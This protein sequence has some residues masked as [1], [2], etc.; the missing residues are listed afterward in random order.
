MWLFFP[1]WCE[2]SIAKWKFYEVSV[3]TTKTESYKEK[4]QRALWCQPTAAVQTISCKPFQNSSFLLT[5]EISPPGGSSEYQEISKTLRKSKYSNHCSR[6][7]LLIP[8]LFYLSTFSLLHGRWPRKL[9]LFHTVFDFGIPRGNCS[10]N[11]RNL[12]LRCS[13]CSK[14]NSH[15]LLLFREDTKYLHR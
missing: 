4:H 7:I 14:P 2:V 11:N 12:F 13:E 10:F 9:L 6:Y 3:S 5:A 8:Y 15:G 1:N